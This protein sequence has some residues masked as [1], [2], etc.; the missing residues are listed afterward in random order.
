M[1]RSLVFAMGMLLLPAAAFISGV[2]ANEFYAGHRI[3]IIDFPLLGMLAW[4]AVVYLLLAAGALAALRGPATI[5]PPLAHNLLIRLAQPFRQR[6]AAATPLARSLTRFGA[7]WLRFSA[8]LTNSRVRRDLHLVV[9]RNRRTA[10][11]SARR[12]QRRQG[13]S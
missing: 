10:A 7:D 13:S 9:P 2:A 3:N 5:R 1:K 11:A 12:R 8:P 4:N 6:F